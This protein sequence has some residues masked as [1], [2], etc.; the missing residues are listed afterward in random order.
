MYEH[1][2]SSLVLQVIK[3]VLSSLQRKG[4]PACVIGEIALNYFNVPR[5]VHVE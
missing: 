2:E 4:I 3:A 1:R 5:V